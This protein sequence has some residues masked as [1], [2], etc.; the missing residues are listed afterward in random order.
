[1]KEMPFQTPTHLRTSLA[2]RIAHGTFWSLIGALL[3]R[4]LMLLA[5]ILVARIL[6]K[7]TYGEFGMIRST[8]GLFGVFAGFGLGLTATKYVA[9]FRHSNPA[10]AGRVIALSEVFALVTGTV[11]AVIIYVFAPWL[12]KNTINAPHLSLELRITAFIV[13]VSSLNG[14]QTGA[15]AGLEAFKSIAKV[16]IAGG[17]SAFPVLVGAS[18]LGGVSGATWGLLLNVVIIYILNLLALNRETAR[19]GVPISFRGFL[20]ERQIVWGFSFP[21]ASGGFLVSFVLWGCAALL[22]NQ[23]GGYAQMGIYTAADQWRLAVLFVPGMVS[24]ITLPMLSS[25]VGTKDEAGYRKTLKYSLL[26]NFGTGFIIAIPIVLLAPWIM[27]SYGPGFEDG[28]TI[29]LC[30]VLSAVLIATSS[31]LGQVFASNDKMWVG[32]VFNLVWGIT[33]TSMC[34]ILVRNG[35]GALGMALS[36]VVSYAL[37]LVWSAIYSYRMLRNAKRNKEHGF[38]KHGMLEYEE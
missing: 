5:S 19:H 18:Y 14:A 13:L 2:H 30:L 17:L 20:S 38:V 10:K 16:N 9:E 7:E 23:P 12:A 22:V 36:F 25:M 37:H 31:V 21:A 33:M 24:R 15:L 26:L 1:M 6:G 27:R 11:V 35:Y 3:S 8:I 28:S 4:A 34:Y 32:F 29:L